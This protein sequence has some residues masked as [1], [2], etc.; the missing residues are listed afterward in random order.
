MDWLMSDS[1]MANVLSSNAIGPLMNADEHGWRAQCDSH[2]TQ[3][4]CC[5]MADACDRDCIPDTV[6]AAT[7]WRLSVLIC[8]HLWKIPLNKKARH[9]AMPGF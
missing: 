4:Q 3:D 8:V 7:S 6:P 5:S 1:A 2:S 9:L